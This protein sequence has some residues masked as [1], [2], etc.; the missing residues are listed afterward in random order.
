MKVTF[1]GKYTQERSHAEVGRRTW[2]TRGRPCTRFGFVNTS[3]SWLVVQYAR[4][5]CR[6]KGVRLDLDVVGVPSSLLS[7]LLGFACVSGNDEAPPSTGV[8]SS[9]N[10]LMK[11]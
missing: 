11:G 3:G 4:G 7:Y 10:D 9:R 8:S 1:E 5:C 2:A 6:L